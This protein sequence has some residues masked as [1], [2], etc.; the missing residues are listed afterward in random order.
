MCVLSSFP[1]TI[2]DQISNSLIRNSGQQRIFVSCVPESTGLIRGRR[3]TKALP[4]IGELSF[5]LTPHTVLVHEPMHVG[6]E[7]NPL[8]V[9]TSSSKGE[10]SVPN[11]MCQGTEILLQLARQ[12]ILIRG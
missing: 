5:V 8:F 9:F 11:F 1:I 12:P 7:Y 3:V 4:S 6:C 10:R 2:T